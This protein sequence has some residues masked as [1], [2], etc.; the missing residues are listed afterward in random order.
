VDRPEIP[1]S[2]K[3][4]PLDLKLEGALAWGILAAL[5]A[6]LSA[7]VFLFKR[8][9]VLDPDLMGILQAMSWIWV[10]GL[11]IGLGALGSWRHRHQ[12]RWRPIGWLAVGV[13]LAGLVQ[14]VQA[15]INAPI[16]PSLLED[17]RTP[18]GF[19]LQTTGTTCMAAAFANA[20]ILEGRPASERTCAEQLGTTRFGTT[21][22][23]LQRAASRMGVRGRFVE[24][25]P[26]VLARIGHPA[27]LTLW[28][29]EG[30][31]HAVTWYGLDGE[32][33]NL[34]VDP[35]VG[36]LRLP[37]DALRREL[38]DRRAFAIQTGNRP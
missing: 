16:Y 20:L 8:T 14:L 34:L 25:S 30:T 27:L 19:V 31:R 3:S 5:L 17:R 36:P 24:A 26:S 29:P 2:R 11:V 32:G 4:S 9:Q 33:R 13:L 23:A 12:G 10:Q 15:R 22:A 6:P 37:S 28:T 7:L 35:V 21:S 1:H 38:A 18:E